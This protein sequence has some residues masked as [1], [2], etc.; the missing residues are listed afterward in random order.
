M[1]GRRSPATSMRPRRAVGLEALRPR[2]VLEERVSRSGAARCQ[3][4]TVQRAL[5][6]AR[7][8]RSAVLQV[9]SG[10]GVLQS[11]PP[12]W[13]CGALLLSYYRESV[14]PGGRI[15]TR[16]VFQQRTNTS[17][18]CRSHPEILAGCSFDL[19]SNSQKASKLY[20]KLYYQATP[21]TAT[22][23]PKP[24]PAFQQERVGKILFLLVRPNYH[25]SWATTGSRTPYRRWP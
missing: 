19:G 10:R 5:T 21:I 3:Y 20:R 13:Q 6:M 2:V 11:Q 7:R 17:E 15:A 24:S 22:V 14:L 23:K 18:S 4:R 12:H 16:Q 25:G 1:S 8:T 9:W